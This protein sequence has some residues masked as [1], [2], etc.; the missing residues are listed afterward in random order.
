MRK[1]PT[2]CKA[3]CA[4]INDL[5]YPD[6]QTQKGSPSFAI[7]S[8]SVLITCCAVATVLPSVLLSC[9][10]IELHLYQSAPNCLQM[11]AHIYLIKGGGGWFIHPFPP[12]PPP[13]RELTSVL[14]V[15]GKVLS[16]K[17]SL[18]FLW[19]R[20]KFIW[21]CPSRCYRL[22]SLALTNCSAPQ[23]LLILQPAALPLVNT[24]SPE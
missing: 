5:V 6:K 7:S 18:I 8:S 2:Q 23:S 16:T 17:T 19:I 9:W 24:C 13:H 11:D 10:L 12:D 20:R 15:R 21:Y 14:S 1:E 3:K 22:F 4:V